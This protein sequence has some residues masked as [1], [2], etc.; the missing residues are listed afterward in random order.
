MDSD[1]L[2][3]GLSTF[4]PY[5]AFHHL[6]KG[7]KLGKLSD[8]WD[9]GSEFLAASPTQPEGGCWRLSNWPTTAQSSVSA[10]IVRQ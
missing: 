7:R 4:R 6:M 10:V 5:T 3:A 8:T 1:T 2:P 9:L